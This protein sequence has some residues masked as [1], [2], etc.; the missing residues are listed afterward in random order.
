MA[1][2]IWA[3]YMKRNY[4]DPDLEISKEPFEVPDNLTI[5]LDCSKEKEVEEGDEDSKPNLIEEIDC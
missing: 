2:P 4:A 3:L 5:D 1:L